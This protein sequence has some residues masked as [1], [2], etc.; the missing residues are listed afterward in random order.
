MD[1]LAHESDAWDR[2]VPNAAPHERHAT[3]AAPREAAA[4][5]ET[6]AAAGQLR[7]HVTIAAAG[8][9]RPRLGLQAAPAQDAGGEP[10]AKRR[11]V[12]HEDE[13]CKDRDVDNVLRDVGVLRVVRANAMPELLRIDRLADRD[14][15]AVRLSHP[16]RQDDHAGQGHRK[17]HQRPDGQHADAD[18]ECVRE[19]AHGTSRAREAARHRL[20]PGTS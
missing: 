6:A 10:H 20:R 8:G 3:R 2:H 13:R 12:Q 14:G 19:R 7:P 16:N 1:E 5:A 11:H 15:G 17:P 9:V 4:A 18:V